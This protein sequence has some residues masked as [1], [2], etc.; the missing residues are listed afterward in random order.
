MS[1]DALRRRLDRIEVRR[2]TGHITDLCNLAGHPSPIA[3]DAVRDW[4]T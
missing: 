3:A 2:S 1:L 4:R